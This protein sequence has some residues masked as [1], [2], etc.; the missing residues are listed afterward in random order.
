MK[1]IINIANQKGGVGKTTTVLNLGV[2][3]SLWEKKVL[4]IDFDPQGNS[5]TGIGI[6]KKNLNHTIYN[7]LSGEI[8]IKDAII[9][10]EKNPYLDFIP[11]GEDLSGFPMEVYDDNNRIYYLKNLVDQIK[12]DY[13]YILI[14][15]PPSL[16]LLTLNSIVAAT[17]VL[18]PVQAEFYALEGLA[19]LMMTL[20]KVERY[21]GKKV[22]I[23]GFLV[24]MYDVRT[25]ISKQ[26][27][28]ELTRYFEKKV[29][30]TIIPRNVRI[31]EAPG[32]GET[33]LTYAPASKGAF[34]YKELIAE[35]L[36]K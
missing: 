17:D 12:N 6:L 23:L 26:V 35:L 36:E 20:K 21:T 13:E 11:A 3:L 28:Q 31:S 18:I 25:S 24:T 7:V 8:N 10:F 1:K 19:Q 15:S 33:V 22:N 2:G 34:A 16:N 4:I 30:T 5:T 32:Y 9:K 14:D 27:H 29:L